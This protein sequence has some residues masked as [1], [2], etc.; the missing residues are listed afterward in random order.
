MNRFVN[1][2]FN[3]S[4]TTAYLAPKPSKKSFAWL[5][6]VFV[7]ARLSGILWLLQMPVW[8]QRDGAIL[9]R[10]LVH[11]SFPGTQNSPKMKVCGLFLPSHLP[12]HPTEDTGFFPWNPFT[13]A[14]K[15]TYSFMDI[16]NIHKMNFCLKS[17]H[18]N[19]NSGSLKTLILKTEQSH[20]SFLY[21]SCIFP[22]VHMTL[23][24][25]GIKKIKATS[26]LRQFLCLWIVKKTIAALETSTLSGVSFI[27]L[28]E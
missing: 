18:E 21:Y 9:V 27:K 22:S 4:K 5:L 19:T 13:M 7:T 2:Y 14:K 17:T 26:D 12:P 25:L 23:C 6:S 16:F 11:T 20:R 28:A 24:F 1:Y 3:I 10:I 8:W 15:H